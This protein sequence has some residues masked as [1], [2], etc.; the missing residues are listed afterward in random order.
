MSSGSDDAMDVPTIFGRLSGRDNDVVQM[1]EGMT[2]SSYYQ[3]GVD[4]SDAFVADLKRDADRLVEDSMDNI[5]MF[6]ADPVVAVNTATSMVGPGSVQNASGI[7]RTMELLDRE[8]A[9]VE[10]EYKK[11]YLRHKAED[12]AA[13]LRREG[14]ES[15]ALVLLKAT[16]IKGDFPAKHAEALAYVDNKMKDVNDPA[17][18]GVFAYSKLGETAKMIKEAKG[19]GHGWVYHSPNAPSRFVAQPKEAMEGAYKK[20]G[21]Q[22][23][24]VVAKYDMPDASG[25]KYGAETVNHFIGRQLGAIIQTKAAIG[26]LRAMRGETFVP[27]AAEHV[28]KAETIASHFPSWDEKS[29]AGSA[30]AGSDKSQAMKIAAF[31]AHENNKKVLSGAATVQGMMDDTRDS[32]RR[33]FGSDVKPGHEFDKPPQDL[34]TGQMLDRLKRAGNK[35]H[36]SFVIA[37]RVGAPDAKNGVVAIGSV[38]EKHAAMA[39]ADASFKNSTK[40]IGARVDDFL[41]KAVGLKYG[42]FKPV[43]GEMVNGGY[44]LSATEF[45]PGYLEGHLAVGDAMDESHKFDVK[46]YTLRV[47]APA[48]SKIMGEKVSN[49]SAAT[50]RVLSMTPKVGADGKATMSGG[51]RTLIL[52][53]SM[54]AVIGNEFSLLGHVEQHMTASIPT[55][56]GDYKGDAVLSDIAGAKIDGSRARSTM[57]ACHY[58]PRVHDA[59]SDEEDD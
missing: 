4:D 50:L 36:N 37:G 39:Q 11:E 16:D 47:T 2:A 26:A 59:D 14:K 48:E 49:A 30:P 18:S 53:S 6:L 58:R 21:E 43:N 55:P 29:I 20:S 35:A 7:L 52:E 13:R 1:P 27:T 5:Q 15:K 31:D 12:L 40:D 24:N 23:L 8:R 57:I 28:S 44:K 25:V 33:I 9:V 32:I 34:T 51:S 42:D 22:S 54:P 38:F 17:K 45:V 3:S 19:A 41:G 56:S 46:G 10:N